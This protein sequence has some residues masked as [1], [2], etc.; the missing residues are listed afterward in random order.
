MS[1]PRVW[2]DQF[3]CS[4]AGLATSFPVGLQNCRLITWFWDLFRVSSTFIWCHQP[5]NSTTLYT[6]RRTLNALFP[7]QQEPVVSGLS[8]SAQSDLLFLWPDAEGSAFAGGMV[9]Q[10][11]V[12]RGQAMFN[13]SCTCMYSCTH[14]CMDD[15][16]ENA[17]SC[18]HMHLHV[19]LVWRLCPVP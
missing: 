9:V 3:Q 8:T 17:L 7:I 1:K 11:A 19:A 16:S 12:S 5:L 18:I 15:G 10:F 13:V 2:I 14:V 6:R 4:N